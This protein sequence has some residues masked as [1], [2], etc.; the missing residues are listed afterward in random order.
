MCR[1]VYVLPV[2]GM[3][4]LGSGEWLGPFINQRSVPIPHAFD[5]C[6]TKESFV[7]LPVLWWKAIA[8]NRRG[9]GFDFGFAYDLLPSWT[10]LIVSSPFCWLYP[11]LH[12]QNVLLRTVYLDDALAT[13][14]NNSI[15][16]AAQLAIRS[17][18]SQSIDLD[19]LC[20]GAG[21]DTRNLRLL[22]GCLPLTRG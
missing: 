14:V 10:R 1:S 8:G 17:N 18:S 13:I 19:V 9:R 20:L 6:N 2:R 3:L 12:H 7:N 4:P 5:R 15:I 22:N 16:S 11:N 21:F